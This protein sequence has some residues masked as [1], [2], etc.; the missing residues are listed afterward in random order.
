MVGDNHIT[1]LGGDVECIVFVGKQNL[2]KALRHH[3]G[4]L[5][6]TATENN[7]T[8]TIVVAQ[9]GRECYGNALIARL[10]TCNRSRNPIAIVGQLPSIVAIYLNVHTLAIGAKCNYLFIQRNVGVIGNFGVTISIFGLFGFVVGVYI[11]APVFLT[12]NHC[13]HCKQCKECKKFFHSI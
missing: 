3:Q 12:T 1:T 9:I 4:F 6:L 13:K 11:I 8:L 7:S 5:C 2:F 10:A